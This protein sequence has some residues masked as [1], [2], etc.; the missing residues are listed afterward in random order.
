MKTARLFAGL[1]AAVLAVSLAACGSSEQPGSGSN[2]GAAAA[3]SSPAPP[4]TWKPGGAFTGP[5]PPRSMPGPYRTFSLPP[6]KDSNGYTYTV[7]LEIGVP[8][9]FAIPPQA[10]NCEDGGPPADLAPGQYAIPYS[11]TVR[12]TTGQ[13]APMQEPTVP[14]IE[15]W[16]QEIPGMT[17]TQWMGVSGWGAGIPTLQDGNGCLDADNGEN[18]PAGYSD[19]LFGLMGPVTLH[20]MRHDRFSLAGY[21]SSSADLMDVTPV[22]DVLPAQARAWLASQPGS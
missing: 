2:P 20:D 10:E 22:A 18:L 13:E 19:A 6:Y 21:T 12:N 4:A 14:N 16:G 15:Y 9:H 3:A 11:M 5:M 1:G 8:L 7:S 17:P